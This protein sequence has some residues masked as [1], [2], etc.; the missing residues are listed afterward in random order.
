MDYFDLDLDRPS[1]DPQPMNLDTT[2][3]HFLEA[4]D[5]KAPLSFEA[6]VGQANGLVT[7][8]KRSANGE[9][10]KK[11]TRKE[12][13]EGEE[14]TGAEAEE[15]TGAKAG[16][17]ETSLRNFLDKTTRAEYWLCIT[18]LAEGEDCATSRFKVAMDCEAPRW[19]GDVQLCHGSPSHHSKG[20]STKAKKEPCIQF[21]LLI[22]NRLSLENG[23][24]KLTF[25]VKE[26]L[27][28]S[29]IV[30]NSFVRAIEAK[31][32][33]HLFQ[34]QLEMAKQLV[35]YAGSKADIAYLIPKFSLEEEFN[36]GAVVYV[37]YAKDGLCCSQDPATSRNFNL[38]GVSVVSGMKLSPHTVGAPYGEANDR[39]PVAYLGHAYALV[40][41][42]YSNL[43]LPGSW[44]VPSGKGDY[45][46]IPE[47][48]VVSESGTLQCRIG[49]ALSKPIYENDQHVVEVFVWIGQ[50]V[51]AAS[52]SGDI[53][54]L[55]KGLQS[56]VDRV[57]T[58]KFD[59]SELVAEGAFVVRLFLKVILL[60][61]VLNFKHCLQ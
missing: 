38:F 37:F 19:S 28:D 11:R 10:G 20:L 45:F 42:D 30:I 22:T 5:R 48:E 34:D 51:A 8:R 39:V 16:A 33:T 26:R 61:P 50:N 4:W 57:E 47:S 43:V 40:D 60:T 1:Q 9:A 3:V 14:G 32:L 49:P 31:N 29:R 13:E 27:D 54:N 53:S 24:E 25:E 17:R 18:H 35:T 56:V 52:C 21:K 15:G 36:S 58:V 7:M 2:L 55:C 59:Q 6:T 41:K 23:Q 46:A 44:M 12:E